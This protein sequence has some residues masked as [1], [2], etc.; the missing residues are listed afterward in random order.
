[1]IKERIKIKKGDSFLLELENKD[2]IA[3]IYD[4]KGVRMVK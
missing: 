3:I 1:M 2:T 4:D